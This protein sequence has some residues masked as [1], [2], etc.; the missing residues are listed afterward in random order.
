MSLG[1]VFAHPQVDTAILGTRNPD[2]MRSNIELVE[3][4]LSLGEPVVDELY[5]R[6][7]ELDDGWLG[8]Q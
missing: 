6:W 3:G 5:R 1:F 8:Q 2:H 7:D 4:G